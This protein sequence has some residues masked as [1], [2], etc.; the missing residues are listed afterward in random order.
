MRAAEFRKIITDLEGKL[1]HAEKHVE[2]EV[3]KRKQYADE[4]SLLKGP[5][6]SVSNRELESARNEIAYLTDVLASR[7]LY[8]KILQARLKV[9][10]AEKKALRFNV[11][12]T[13]HGVDDYG[14][15]N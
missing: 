7:R 15:P 11:S 10:E 8:I 2:V 9:S 14:K 3:M 12:N 4:L 13:V 1:K 5:A 6:M